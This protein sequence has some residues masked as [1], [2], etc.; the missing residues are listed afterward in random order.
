MLV[1]D[2]LKG[3]PDAVSAVWEKTIVFHVAQLVDAKQVD[4]AVAVSRG[5]SWTTAVT[6]PAL[7]RRGGTRSIH[8]LGVVAGSGSASPKDLAPTTFGKPRR[9]HPIGQIRLSLPGWMVCR[10]I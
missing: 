3:L 9:M 6:P 1:C 4:A 2:G 7:R 8:F 5:W 10:P